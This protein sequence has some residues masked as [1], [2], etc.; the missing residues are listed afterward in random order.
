VPLAEVWR[1]IAGCLKELAEGRISRIEDRNVGI[2][3]DGADEPALMGVE[4]GDDGAAG[5]CA[6]AGRGVV[7]GE[8]YAALP[9]VFV[10]V[11]HEAPEVFFGAADA[12]GEDGRPTQ[13]VD[14]DEDNVRFRSWFGDVLGQTKASGDTGACD[15][16][17][18]FQEV[19]AFHCLFS[20]G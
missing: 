20:N 8:L 1:G 14:K 18:G 19:S 12:E 9:D 7:V 4:A 15:G 10:E 6:G 5:R 13:L 3:G 11:R 16:G 2:R 17:G